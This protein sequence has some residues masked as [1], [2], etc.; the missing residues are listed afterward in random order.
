MHLKVLACEVAAR[1]IYICAAQS[2]NTVSID[3][4]T[5]GLHDNSDLMRQRLQQE[6]DAIDGSQYDAILLGY[7]LCNNGIVGLRPRDR[8]LV[9][10]RAH[11]CI[12]FF[13]GSKQRYAEEF[14][15]RPGTYYYTTG[16]L[17]YPERRG[18]RLEQMTKSG[19]GD[20]WRQMKEFQKLVEKYGEAN[21]RYL[22]EVM[23]DWETKYNRGAFIEFDFSRH[24]GLHEKA[25]DICNKRG[26]E[27]ELLEGRLGLLQNWLDGAWDDEHFLIVEP[28]YEV[29]ADY[30]GNIVKSVPAG[31][32]ARE[33]DHE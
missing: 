32:S 3:L 28:G 29:A 8:K 2:V 22:M 21:A 9:V 25:R 20:S 12:T 17:E 14:E 16:W 33:G 27:F 15:Q 31:D 18:E 11:D 26:W 5:Q 13:L 23:G 30:R 7:G 6:I 24:L 19:L 1:E 10:P 4:L